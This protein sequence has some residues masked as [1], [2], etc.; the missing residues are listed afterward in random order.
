MPGPHSSLFHSVVDFLN[1]FSS[2][3]LKFR[4]PPFQGTQGIPTQVLRQLEP[5]LRAQREKARWFPK[6]R[7]LRE[8]LIKEVTS[9]MKERVRNGALASQP[10]GKTPGKLV[11]GFLGDSDAGEL[12][13]Y[14]EGVIPAPFEALV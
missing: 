14:E 2:Q 3:T 9:R 5:I 13:T 10:G 7:S 11:R 12:F 6:F 1:K 4:K 8:K